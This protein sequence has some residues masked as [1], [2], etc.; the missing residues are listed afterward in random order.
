MGMA[1]DTAAEVQGWDPRAWH[2]TRCYPALLIFLPV[3]FYYSSLDLL[4]PPTFT[5]GVTDI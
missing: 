2:L 5:P 1:R 3:D 4:S